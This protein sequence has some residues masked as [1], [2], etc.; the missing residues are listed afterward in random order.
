MAKLRPSPSLPL[1]LFRQR[2]LLCPF[3]QRSSR[4]ADRDSLNTILK[5]LSDSVAAASPSATSSPNP[6]HATNPGHSTAPARTPTTRTTRAPD[7]VGQILSTLTNTVMEARGG[8]PYPNGSMAGNDPLA[9]FAHEPHR[10]HCYS[11]KH[12]TH[13]TLSRPNNDP[14][15][16]VSSGQVG[17]KKSARG[18]WDAGYQ[19]ATYVMRLIKDRGWLVPGHKDSVSRIEVVFRGFGEGRKAFESALQG[20]EG[21][22]MRGLVVSVT[23][24]TRTKFGGTRSQNPRRL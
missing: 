8:M 24:A 16:A 1:R 19:L 4:P 7:E 13:L 21:R 6:P 9:V 11:T 3:S 5:E 17:F 18:S 15:L 14:V 10:L 23:D 22:Y 2:P 12:N 20:T